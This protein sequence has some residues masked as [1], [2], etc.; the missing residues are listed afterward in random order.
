[1]TYQDILYMRFMKQ[2]KVVRVARAD[3]LRG[4]VLALYPSADK[5]IFYTEAFHEIDEKSERGQIRREA[6]KD[7]VWLKLLDGEPHE[8]IVANHEI[9]GAGYSYCPEGTDFFTCNNHRSFRIAEDKEEP[10]T[11]KVA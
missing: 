6:I 2:G 1:M 7:A 4:L 5:N 11:V 10:T 9:H 8:T 3:T